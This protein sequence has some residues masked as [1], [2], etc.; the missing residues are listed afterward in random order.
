MRK[1]R[2]ALC[3]GSID[4]NGICTDC[5]Y[6][7]GPSAANGRKP[8][9]ER[10]FGWMVLFLTAVIST[11]L[12]F[13]IIRTIYADETDF[14][15]SY[16]LGPGIHHIGSDIP[17][18]KY[19]IQTENGKDGQMNLFQFEDNVF[20]PVSSSIF[21]EQHKD[22]RN[23]YFL[24]NGYYIVIGPGTELGFYTND[25]K[26]LNEEQIKTDCTEEYPL[27]KWSD[28]TGSGWLRA[29]KDFPA[30]VYDIVYTPGKSNWDVTVQFNVP[31][32]VSDKQE[33]L[34][35]GTVTFKV[36]DGRQTF[37]GVPMTEGSAITVSR[38]GA[39]ITLKPAEYT[40]RAF[41]DMTRGYSRE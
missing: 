19:H 7:N 26:E 16:I 4:T 9:K 37:T 34:F 3:G 39:Q 27:S 15:N 29:G 14:E 23:D 35:E 40:N 10:D 13:G 30:G 1:R 17:A 31:N 11:G 6:N 36:S 12:V 2:C 18:G 24:T 8:G 21:M 25:N 22:E 33:E 38:D 5:G 32:P 20:F 28:K 41:Y